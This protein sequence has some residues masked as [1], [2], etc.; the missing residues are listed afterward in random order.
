MLGRTKRARV[1]RNLGAGW[2][3][4]INADKK[5]KKKREKERER[6]D[7]VREDRYTER[8]RKTVGTWKLIRTMFASAHAE[9]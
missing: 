4:Q 6:E 5:K 1:E 7:Q 8:K 2:K 9:G 3:G